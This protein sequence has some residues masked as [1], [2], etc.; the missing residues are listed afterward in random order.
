MRPWVTAGR[1]EGSGGYTKECKVRTTTSNFPPL[2]DNPLGILFKPH[3][4]SPPPCPPPSSL[5]CI[6]AFHA[7]LLFFLYRILPSVCRRLQRIIIQGD[8]APR[9]PLIVSRSHHPS[10]TFLPR[11]TIAEV[12]ERRRGVLSFFFT[13]ASRKHKAGG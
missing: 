5:T 9:L 1:L 6:T 2:S 12:R 13:R 3:S 4:P 7:L 10:G 11:S 8:A